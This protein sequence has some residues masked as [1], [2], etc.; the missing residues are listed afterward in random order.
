MCP[1]T[2]PQTSE[3]DQ[4]TF[5]VN[6]LGTLNVIRA[7]LPALRKTGD[8]ARIVNVGSLSGV[9]ASPG[10]ATYSASK[11]AIEG[12][13]DSLRR[14]VAPFGISVSLLEPGYVTSSMGA[15]QYASEGPLHGVSKAGYE[16]YRPIFEGFFEDDRRGSR[17]ENSD[18]PAHTTTAA[19]TD[20]IVSRTPRTRYA[21][22]HAVGIPVS[23]LIWLA[24]L[25]PDRVVDVLVS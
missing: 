2:R 9:I 13:T 17:P 10:S 20:A 8:G 23:V 6:V 25:L 7:F 12:F 4:F 21:C 24:W 18:S 19:I 3:A 11:F 16:L 14:E 5:G 1:S 22:A 15:K